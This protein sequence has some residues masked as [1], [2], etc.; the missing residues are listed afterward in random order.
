MLFISIPFHFS[1]C[2]G[3]KIPARI[4][5]LLRKNAYFLYFVATQIDIAAILN[6]KKWMSQN[7]ICGIQIQVT[8]LLD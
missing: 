3:T 1:N 8:L 4:D 2:K 6:V 5:R 7:N